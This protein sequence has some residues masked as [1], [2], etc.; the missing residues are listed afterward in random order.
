MNQ[1]QYLNFIQ[2]P[3]FVNRYLDALKGVQEERVNNEIAN[4]EA[5]RYPLSNEGISQFA[6]E[7]GFDQL[8]TKQTTNIIP[9]KKINGNN[10]ELTDATEYENPV[11]AMLFSQKNIDFLQ[12]ECIKMIYYKTNKKYLIS[13]QNYS[14]V[15]QLITHV[16]NNITVPNYYAPVGSEQFKQ[17]ISYLNS[18]ILKELFEYVYNSLKKYIS[19]SEFL[20]NGIQPI[21]RPINMSIKGTNTLITSN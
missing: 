9:N 7:R 19:Y 16:Y 18:F 2:S 12:Q 17:E 20:A 15:L 3:Q 6:R 21:D 10:I 4:T 11:K 5:A 13:P 14:Q 1:E 8:F